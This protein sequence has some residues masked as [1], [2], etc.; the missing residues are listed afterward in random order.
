MTYS[1]AE[2]AKPD[3]YEEILSAAA[4]CFRQQGFAA[5]SIDTVARY[6]GSTKGRIYHYFPSK[7]DLF[8]VVRD[9]GME[10]AFEGVMPG[11]ETK[12]DPVERLALMA[13]G[14]VLTMIQ[15]HAFM[16][17][18]LDGLRMRRYGATTDFQR[19][20]LERHLEQR[21]EFERM[22][23]DVIQEGIEAGQFRE[24][25][26][27]FVVQSFLV[28]VNGPVFW[29]VEREGDDL[30]KFQRIADEVVGFAMGGLGVQWTA[31]MTRKIKQKTGVSK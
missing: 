8:N 11:Y 22:F 6:L 19:Q 27:S 26:V 21:N 31:E 29:Y 1:A 15:C 13:H 24:G 7:M 4:E 9:R 17:V 5:T 2:Q 14:H 16:Q 25:A 23:R 28:T 30:T 20:A 3:R 10:L 18:L 12:G